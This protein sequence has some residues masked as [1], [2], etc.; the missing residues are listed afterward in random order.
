MQETAFATDCTKR[1]DKKSEAYLNNAKWYR[2]EK[3]INRC[4]SQKHEFWATKQIISYKY[5]NMLNVTV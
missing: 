5:V 2:K 1:F 4:N 3:Q